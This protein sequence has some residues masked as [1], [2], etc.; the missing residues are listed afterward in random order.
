MNDFSIHKWLGLSTLFKTI[1]RRIDN[2]SNMLTFG[3]RAI[4]IE[5]DKMIVST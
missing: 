2:N 4:G 3:A 1:L 5:L